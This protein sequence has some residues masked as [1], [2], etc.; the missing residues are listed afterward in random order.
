MQIAFSVLAGVG[1]LV[2]VCAAFC[3]FATAFDSFWNWRSL[4]HERSFL[5]G[6]ADAG[7]R[8]FRDAWWFTESP[9]TCELLQDLANGMEVSEARDKWR[10]AR[11][12]AEVS[13]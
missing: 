2:A 9:E 1:L 12:K 5:A 4:P 7:H 13:S 11:A 6:R 3:L 8:L 10:A